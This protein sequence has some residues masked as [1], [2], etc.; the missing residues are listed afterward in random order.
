MV[1]Y[2]K[3]T[4]PDTYR[5]YN[6]ITRK[7]WET[8][9]VL[10]MDW[11]RQNP[12]RDRKLFDQIS[13]EMKQPAG[14]DE[15]EYVIIDDEEVK[16][17]S[18]QQF[19]RNININHSADQQQTNENKKL[20][21]ALKK[22][23]TNLNIDE[24]P[25]TRLRNKHNSNI[26]SG[27]ETTAV[28]ID[29][30]NNSHTV[31]FVFNTALASDSGEP[32][33]IGE[34]YNHQDPIEEERWRKAGRTEINNFLKR[35]SWTKYKRNKALEAGRKII[36][37]KVIFTKKRELVGSTAPDTYGTMRYKVRGVTLGYQQIPGIDY[38]ES[39]SPVA[40][41]VAIR[42]AIGIALFDDE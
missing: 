25:R 1:G 36:G 9:N 27:G 6:P 3:N 23:E 41:D 19:G 38:T 22:L 24:A 40:T 12:Q 39:H 33:N 2:A 10:W 16:V 17:G 34:A 11:K 8:R 29:N 35:N 4:T 18:A 13:D 28:A 31:H 32:K 7:V 14:V 37:T 5:M 20:A 30:Q 15:K 42:M 26:S 21:S